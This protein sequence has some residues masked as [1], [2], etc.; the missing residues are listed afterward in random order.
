MRGVQVDDL[1]NKSGEVVGVGAAEPTW[2]PSGVDGDVLRV[3]EDDVA[4][5]I[6][7][8]GAVERPDVKED[9]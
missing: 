5:R 9:G 3:V 1:D 7:V 8:G 6:G 4:V 2:A